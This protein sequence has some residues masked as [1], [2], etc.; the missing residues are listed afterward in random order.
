[1]PKSPDFRE[2]DLA[3]IDEM[4]FIYD[5]R[6][7]CVKTIEKCMELGFIFSPREHVWIYMDNKNEQV[8]VNR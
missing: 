4:N 5:C 8:E 7:S 1:M 3:E 2:Y 6:D